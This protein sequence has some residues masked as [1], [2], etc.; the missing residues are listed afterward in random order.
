MKVTAS[1][2]CCAP[3]ALVPAMMGLFHLA[4]FRIV[5]VGAVPTGFVQEEIFTN[6]N[7]PIDMVF[8]PSEREMIVVQKKG[9]VTVWQDV[10]MDFSYAQKTV[11]LDMSAVVCVNGERGLGG[12]QL[13]PDFD[14]QDNRYIYLYYTYD[15]T[16]QCLVANPA[17][18]DDEGP[19]NRL[20]RFVLSESW[21][22][23]PNSETVLLQTPPLTTRVHNGGKIE[24]GKDGYLYVSI[25]DM[26]I[27][28]ESQSLENLFGSMIR[29]T[30]D[31]GIPPDNPF[32]QDPNSYRCNANGVL[33]PGVASNENNNNNNKCQELYAIGLRNPWRF[34][35]NPNTEGSKVH[36]YINDVGGEVWEEISEGGGGGDDHATTRNGLGITNYGWPRR[37]GPCGHQGTPKDKRTT[38]CDNNPQ[39]FHQPLHFFPHTAEGGCVT[40]GAFVPKGIWPSEYDNGYLFTDY[41]SG[42]VFLLPDSDKLTE[43]C[44]TECNPVHSGRNV[45]AFF[46]HPRIP[47]MRFG[48]Y[49]GGTMA[50][51]YTSNA[52]GGAMRRVYYAASEAAAAEY[53][54]GGAVLLN[55]PPQANIDTNTSW[56]EVGG[57]VFFSGRASSDPDSDGDDNVLL[58]EWD[59]DGDGVVDSRLSEDSYHFPTAGVYQPTLTV[60]DRHKEKSISTTHVVVG[61][62]KTTGY[63]GVVFP[64]SNTTCLDGYDFCGVLE[65]CQGDNEHNATVFGYRLPCVEDDCDCPG[66]SGPLVRLLPGKRYRLTLRNSALHDTNLHTHGLHIVGSGDSD[67][68][69]RIVSA[70]GYCL[71][72]TWDIAK[73]HLGGTNWYHAHHHGVAEAQIGGGAYGMLIVEDNTNLH[74]SLPSWAENELLLQIVQTEQ[75]V[76]GNGRT[77]D[78]IAVNATQ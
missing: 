36:Y 70:D 60:Y 22:I 30:A 34:A 31:G 39:G 33:P 57:T 71:D 54:D 23:D 74:M 6:V 63:P 18:G 76:K 44:L 38:D 68:V 78:L 3:L 61:T 52:N 14:I 59:F 77:N 48:P 11:A 2:L 13:H 29:M 20:S 9:I 55:H 17:V 45:T 35:M 1:S 47:T 69:T 10:D 73:D 53:D 25:G 8:T 24:F 37:E 32:A 51:Y 5:V 72:Y 26:G 21:T 7:F 49:K 46:S 19:V 4:C 41:V 40:G 27:K 58:Y 75:S 12:V 65:F 28:E 15:E 16:G 43:P 62:P 64:W 50:L 42:Q 56:V 67:D 66:V